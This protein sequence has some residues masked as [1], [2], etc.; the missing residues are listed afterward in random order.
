MNNQFVIRWVD[1]GGQLDDN[2]DKYELT[3]ADRKNAELAYQWF[4]SKRCD[5]D[6]YY[7]YEGWVKFSIY[8]PPLAVVNAI[9]TKYPL[10]VLPLV[11]S[12]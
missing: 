12:A 9:A 4:T 5:F 7:S 8:N 1:R 3:I 10:K 2:T 11:K 6:R